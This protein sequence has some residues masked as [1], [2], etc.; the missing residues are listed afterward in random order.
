M[1]LLVVSLLALVLLTARTIVFNQPMDWLGEKEFHFFVNCY[2]AIIQIKLPP[3]L[4]GKRLSDGDI[5]EL[6]ACTAF[7]IP[8]NY[9][10]HAAETEVDFP[11]VTPTGE[12]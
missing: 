9:T 5:I 11:E 12:L 1:Y 4:V 8:T 7:N 2:F 6:I 10:Y 3:F